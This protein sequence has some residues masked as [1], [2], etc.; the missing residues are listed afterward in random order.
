MRALPILLT[1]LPFFAF[2]Q[3][4]SAP[5]VLAEPLWMRI[6]L[7]GGVIAAFVA[8]FFKLWELRQQLRRIDHEISEKLEADVTKLE[9][10]MEARLK[11]EAR[12]QVA[13]LRETYVNALPFHATLLRDHI[14]AVSVKLADPQS[15]SEMA[16][17]FNEIKRYGARELFKD[18]DR[19][20]GTVSPMEFSARCH[21]HLIFA[22]STL[23]YTSV[24][25]LFS[26]RI[27]ALAPFSEADSSFSDGLDRH[28][29]AIGDAFARRNI[30]GDPERARRE[31]E[32]NGLW[33]TVQNNMGA[34][35][36]KDEWYVSYPEFCRIFIDV[37]Q[38]RR[39]DHAF[40]RALDVFGAY[41]GG[42][43]LTAEGANSIVTALNAL[44][45]FL[46]EQRAN[47]ESAE[48]NR[49]WEGR[50]SRRRADC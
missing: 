8:G 22:M 37:D 12:T 18:N 35:V 49:R 29:K 45:T 46:A 7:A 38:P 28:L 17:W 2:A 39:D 14:S 9:V 43:L 33:E 3:P 41:A 1:L 5:T 50:T 13:R 20:K 40:M 6:V 42:P 15:R 30:S 32:H 36:R 19:G 31:A 27:R 11:A 23:Y 16:G 24:F 48:R 44:L 47:R 26:Q 4:V 34:L 21:Y 10:E 25:F